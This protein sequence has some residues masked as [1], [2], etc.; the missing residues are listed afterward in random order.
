MPHVAAG[1]GDGSSD[2]L[3]RSRWI[4][5]PG[6]PRRIEIWSHYFD[7]NL[8][9][10]GSPGKRSWLANLLTEPRF[11]YH[12]KHGIK[13]DLILVVRPI[14]DMAERRA[15]L[16]G[17]VELSK[18]GQPVPHSRYQ[19][20]QQIPLPPPQMTPVFRPAP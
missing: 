6:R 10:A 11:T 5:K 7:G 4:R 20:H 12:I 9:G 13:A 3:Q 15:V 16:T 2:I 18:P 14:R 17:L 1:L 19:R 8:I